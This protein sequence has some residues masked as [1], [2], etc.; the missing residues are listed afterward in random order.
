M[1]LST[2]TYKQTKN[3]PYNSKEGQANHDG[4]GHMALLVGKLIIKLI[5]LN[6][7]TNF[8]TIYKCGC[9]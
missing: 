4:D 8:A 6:Y 2:K 7:D 1:I 5:N 3:N 9:I